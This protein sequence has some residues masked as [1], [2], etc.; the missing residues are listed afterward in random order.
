MHTNIVRDAGLAQRSEASSA[1]SRSFLTSRKQ[2]PQPEDPAALLLA[3]VPV[4][5]MEGYLEMA[6]QP[7]L[8]AFDVN[9]AG[10]AAELACMDPAPPR[11]AMKRSSSIVF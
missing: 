8:I 3:P 7:V 6:M 10:V 4:A 11:Q 5:A 2:L 9:A 1:A